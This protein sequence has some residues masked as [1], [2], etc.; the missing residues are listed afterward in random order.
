MNQSVFFLSLASMKNRMLCTALCLFS[1]AMSVSLLM[2]VQRVREGARESFQNT[3]S[4]TD[5]IVGA[6]TGPVQLLL[7]SV[8]H[9]GNPSNN[10]SWK[11]YRELAEHPEVK[12]AVPVSLG[13]SHRGYR[14]VGTQPDFFSHFK[15]GKSKF[16]E[17]QAGGVFEG[18]FDVVIGSELAKK[19]SY[20]K[21]Q[22]IVLSHGM[23]EVSF[24]DHEDSPFSISGILKKTGTP[25]DRSLF[26]SLNG[27]EAI[28]VG[29]E[30]GAPPLDSVANNESASEH[31]PEPKSVTAVLIGLNSKMGIFHFQ[32]AVNDYDQEALTALLPGVTLRDL[33]ETVNIAETA[34]LVVALFV[35]L[36]GILGMLSSMLTTLNER[37]R[38]LAIIRS[39][40]GK[41]SDIF[42]LLLSE[43]L[44]LGLGGCVLGCILV[45][46]GL[47]V[48]QPLMESVWGLSVP[49]NPPGLVDAGILGGVV[50]LSI[51]AG[52]IPAVK[53]YRQSLTDG[54]AIKL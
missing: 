3:I 54:L 12:W 46:S 19:F 49:V 38:E 33:W 28:H 5:L 51:L 53:A 43:A 20:Q 41:P 10:M 8:F 2:G 29:W 47:L 50:L 17:F 45:Y 18:T 36:S 31:L 48:F 34:L 25:L 37:R 27:L 39:L 42:L 1:I 26:V 52:C 21:G 32:R 23:S 30:D 24:Q 35:V 11:S 16:L 4:G 44:F 15:H 22:K 6:R 40:G 7:Y 9:I 14:V 13:D